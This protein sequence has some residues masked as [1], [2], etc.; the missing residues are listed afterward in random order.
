MPNLPIIVIGLVS[1]LLA[2]IATRRIRLKN[3]RNDFS[4][5]IGR[6]PSYESKRINEDRKTAISMRSE[7]YFV[8]IATDLETSFASR[9][10]TFAQEKEF[11][12]YYADYYQEANT[13]VPR[14][15]KFSIEP[16]EAVVHMS[17]HTAD[18]DKA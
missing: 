18:C 1:I 3:G 16:S 13:L 8:D 17:L 6:I 2:V 5:K 4:A 15:K 12:C 9:Y 10:I 7:C 14:L 11:T